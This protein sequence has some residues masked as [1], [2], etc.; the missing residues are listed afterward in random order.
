MA[1]TSFSD[2]TPDVRERAEAFV[3][4]ANA[5]GL[6]VMVASTLRSCADQGTSTEA[7]DIQ[8]MKIKRAPG[9]R[10][11]HV[12]GRAF[13]LVLKQPSADRYAQLGALG[14]TFGLEWGGDFVSNP[15]PIHF[16]YHPGL[17]IQKLCPDPNDCEGALKAAGL[18][19]QIPPIGVPTPKEQA[20]P[21]WAFTAGAVVG[22][23]GV[24]AFSRGRRR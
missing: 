6:N 4:S 21:L 1:S 20:K 17:D 22:W 10:S 23:F 3:Q 12:W 11:W 14:K 2:L 13:D 19:V 16:Q 15:D 9:C 7:I 5:Q 8:G 18:P 24:L